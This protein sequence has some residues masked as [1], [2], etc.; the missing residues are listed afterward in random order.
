M[1]GRYGRLGGVLP[2]VHEG[3]G[4]S[5]LQKAVVSAVNGGRVY[6]AINSI[7]TTLPDRFT[8][9]ELLAKSH[10]KGPGSMIMAIR[11]LERSFRCNRTASGVW[12]KP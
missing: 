3:V 7:F 8:M 2:V 12:K 9:S 5:D 11:V 6:A 4:M 10:L 1:G